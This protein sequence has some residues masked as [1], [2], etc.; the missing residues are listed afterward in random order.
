MPSTNG[1]K[2][3]VQGGNPISGEIEPQGNKNEAMP[4]MAAACLTD[5]PVT[6]QNIPQIED[7]RLM[8]SILTELGLTSKESDANLVRRTLTLQ[9]SKTP[10]SFPHPDLASR[11]RGSVTLAGPILARTGQVTIPRIGGDR[12]GRRRLDTHLQ[13][14][15]ALGAEISDSKE[16]LQ[17]KAKKLRGADILLDEASVTATE[18]AVCAAA[19]AEGTTILRNA[20][21]EPHVQALA[22][23]LS[24]MGAHIT[25]IGTN[26]L[27]IEGVKSLQGATH[28][29]GP[30]YLEAGSFLALAAVTRGEL[31]IKNAAPQHMR[32]ILQTFAR[33]GIHTEIQGQDIF[34]AKNQ[35]L[36]VEKEFGGAVPHIADAPWPGFPA[37]MTSIALVTA[38]QCKGT[39]LIHEKLFESR[40][41]FVD[42]LLE[43]GARIILC[44]PHRAVILGSDKLRGAKLASP[45]IRAGMALLIAALCAEG[46]SEI[47]N[48]TQIDRGFSRIEER[49]RALGAQIE[50][51]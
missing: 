39:V 6:L 30:D 8:E 31:K 46:E 2:F 41:F 28:R 47:R 38:T 7:V 15:S 3:I 36:E 21:S 50:R 5:Q 13:I 12:I 42:G 34:I 44:D 32:M 18:N 10:S 33:L 24:A 27:T 20:A 22:H 35:K 43:M 14:F 49:L 25:G 23:L 11:L 48:I 4:L 37:D 1:G 9:A 26:T 40:L 17:I 29:V 51:T 19:L 16:G 45:D